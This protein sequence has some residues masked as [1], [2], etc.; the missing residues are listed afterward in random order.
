M[1]K[2]WSREETYSTLSPKSSY[3]GKSGE[4]SCDNLGL[5]F[6]GFV[7]GG[8][9]LICIVCAPRANG[10]TAL[11]KGYAITHS[12]VGDDFF[13]HWSFYEGQDPTHGTVQFTSF[14][15]ASSEGLISASF[16]RIYMGVD[17]TKVLSGWEGRKAVRLESNEWFRDGLFVLDLDHAP[18]ACGAWPAFWMYGEDSQHAWPRWGEY[19]ILEA[20][21][22][23]SFATTTL[24]T[25]DHCDQSSVNKDTDFSGGQWSANQQG[26]P[27]KNCF[28][29]APNEF[30]NQG[31]GQKQPS[32]SWGKALNQ[33]GGG[34]WAAEWDPDKRVIR[35][36]FFRRGQ[37]PADLM[38][39]QPVP[40]NWGL[41]TSFFTLH[42]QFCSPGH[43]KRMRLVFDTTFCGDYGDPTFS[44][45]CP[46][47]G[48]SCH[49]FVQKNPNV[50][51]EAFWS[52]RVLDIYRRPS[53]SP[54]VLSAP[55]GKQYE[56]LKQSGSGGGGGSGWIF[57][58]LVFTTLGLIGCIGICYIMMTKADENN[59]VMDQEIQGFASCMH[60][61]REMDMETT[62]E[63]A[64]HLA[65]NAY[66]TLVAGM[67]PAAPA[68][69]P[70]RSQRMEAASPPAAPRR[71]PTRELHRTFSPPR[72]DTVPQNYQRGAASTTMRSVGVAASNAWSSFFQGQP[73]AGRSTSNMSNPPT[74]PLYYP[75]A[76][77]SPQQG[78]SRR[79][80][81]VAHS[82]SAASG[83]NLPP[84]VSPVQSLRLA[85][86]PSGT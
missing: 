3:R 55:E 6:F 74:Q 47:A 13:S 19:D 85:G 67:A 30:T 84:A 41:P 4:T 72:L 83:W 50:F 35:T 38:R 66:D 42:S 12:F 78:W 25:R 16:D 59:S 2:F 9:L 57:F 27:A 44:S 32:G 65:S 28:V 31:C 36:W 82:P 33:A 81:A 76:R 26:G 80:P 15:E 51:A 20:V 79:Q 56:Q 14:E 24:H 34:T 60:D 63:G 86:S 71:E 69:F 70:Q 7:L 54:G 61:V 43:F 73:A 45:N 37:E 1:D 11:T 48:M 5:W 22:N 68:N 18:V 46:N 23:Q 64:R 21:H 29:Q 40:D 10:V 52:I 17:A 77:G 62:V 39:K 49:D 75:S 8:A 58:G 53:E